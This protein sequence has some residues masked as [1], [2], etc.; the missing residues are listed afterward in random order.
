MS[1]DTSHARRSIFNHNWTDYQIF[2][3]GPSRPVAN[4]LSLKELKHT[5]E[6]KYI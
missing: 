6:P 4:T 3:P 2:K 5:S 1:S